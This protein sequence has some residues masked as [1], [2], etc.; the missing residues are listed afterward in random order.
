MFHWNSGGFLK[1]VICNCVFVIVYL[2]L[3][4]YICVLV[5]VY[6][7]IRIK[8]KYKYLYWSR[9]RRSPT[10]RFHWQ[11]QVWIPREAWGRLSSLVGI[12]SNRYFPI[13]ILS[14]LVSI[15]ASFLT[16]II[17]APEVGWYLV[18]FPDWLESIRA[19]WYKERP[20]TSSVPSIEF[21]TPL[22][23]YCN[24]GNWQDLWVY[25]AG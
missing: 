16:D 14:P 8:Y 11:G 19:S 1:H 7:Y 22:Y 15:A 21:Q 5:F 3:C 6:L 23:F 24:S 10:P 13:Q 17:F 18:R 12:V 25:W 9:S 4:I 2:Y 20:Q